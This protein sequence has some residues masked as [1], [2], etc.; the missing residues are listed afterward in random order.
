MINLDGNYKLLSVG[1]NTAS[2]LKSVYKQTTISYTKMNSEP[3]HTIAA[4]CVFVARVYKTPKFIAMLKNF[5]HCFYNH[6]DEIK[7]TPGMHK[8]LN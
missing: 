2:K 3:V 4:D 1:E 5:R 8:A 7:E 6:L